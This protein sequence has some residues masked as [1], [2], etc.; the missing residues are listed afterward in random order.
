MLKKLLKKF[1]TVLYVQIWEKKIK[2]TNISTGE[3]LEEKALVAIRTQGGKKAIEAVGNDASLI[4]DK[5]ITVFEPFVHKRLLLSNFTIAEILL[6]H[7]F[8]LLLKKERAIFQ[9]RVIIHP[10]EKIDGGL[11]QIEIRAFRELAI[12]AGARDVKVHQGVELSILNF[13]YEALPDDYDL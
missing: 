13:D 2:V 5:N 12:G 10:M 7:E 4:T 3:V 11:G 1:G 8:N 9:P 6:Q